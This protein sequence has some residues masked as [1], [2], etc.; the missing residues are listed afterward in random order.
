M[1]DL[2]TPKPTCPAIVID[3][4]NSSSIN[5]FPL[6]DWSLVVV[7][8]SIALLGV[9]M[10]FSA[11][12]PFAEKNY[13]DP[14]FFVF[15]QIKY[16]L[17]GLTTAFVLFKV[18][19]DDWE[20]YGPILLVGALILLAVVLVPGLG[21]TVNG[22]RRWLKLGFMTFQVSEAAK[23]FVII[24]LAGYLV[25]RGDR[26]KR[27]FGAFLRPLVVICCAGF[28][29]L[30]EPDFG[31]TVVI[32]ITAMGMLFVGGV[33]FGQF[34]VLI[35]AFAGGAAIL[36]LS[37]DYR[38]RRL[39]SFVNP[40]E[41]PFKDGFQ[42]S[43]SLIAIGSGS[44]NGVGLG[45]SVQKLLYLPESHTDF[46][47]AVYAEE[48]GLVGVTVLVVL[49]AY[50]VWRCLDIASKADA[51]GSRFAGFVVLGIGI[52][53]GLQVF[54]N[55]GVN[56]GILPTKGITLPLM[57]YGGSSML[58]FSVAFALV[59]RVDLETRQLKAD[60]LRKSIKRKSRK[61]RA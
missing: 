20:R 47:F 37:S 25:R 28:L 33:K 51:E 52:W 13:G 58:V 40:W 39:T 1:S 46:L 55:V 27:D 2:T 35:T 9:V 60:R 4:T 61:V 49:F 23:L 3:D 32:V 22:S 36:V 53:F 17:L 29:I 31:G 57:S 6:V 24:Y 15:N 12:I 59:L 14:F 5:D 18:P 34:F 16:M 21:K 50:V 10:I 44:W 43:Q 42:L 30:M 45:S 54:I 56:M 26:V 19:V 41:D 48:T 38:L 7:L 8:T 11:S